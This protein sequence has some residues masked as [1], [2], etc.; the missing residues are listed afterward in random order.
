MALSLRKQFQAAQKKLKKQIESKVQEAALIV[1]ESLVDTA[2]VDTGLHAANFI[3]SVNRKTAP[4]A[5][6]FSDFGLKTP[7]GLTGT[8]LITSIAA[9]TIATD[10]PTSFKTGKEIVWTNSVPYVFDIEAFITMRAARDMAIARA[11]AE[12]NS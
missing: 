1:A 5:L 10:F 4:D 2:K 12:L 8:R 6:D 3:P 7:A 11:K 9:K